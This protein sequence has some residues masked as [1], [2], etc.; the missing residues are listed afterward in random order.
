MKR[1]QWVSFQAKLCAYIYVD[2]S[3]TIWVFLIGVSLS[4]L[5]VPTIQAI[6]NTD[7]YPYKTC[8]QEPRVL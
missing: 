1:G 3:D 6:H 8:T 5:C 2:V 7:V 4:K